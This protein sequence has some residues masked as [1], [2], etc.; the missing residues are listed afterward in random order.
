VNLYVAS[1][2]GVDWRALEPA[3]RINL[4]RLGPHEYRLQQR[5]E[6]KVPSAPGRYVVRAW[7][8]PD[9]RVAESDDDN[10]GSAVVSLVVGDVHAYPDLLVDLA[11]VNDLTARPGQTIPVPLVIENRG[12]KPAAGD[13]G[14]FETALFYADTIQADWGALDPVQTLTWPAVEPNG[15]VERIIPLAAPDH[16]GTYYVR[17]LADPTN[18]VIESNEDNFSRVRRIIVA[19]EPA[20]NRPPALGPLP[21]TIIAEGQA[22]QQ[23]LSAVDPDGDWL[24]FTAEPLPAGAVIRGDQFAWTPG[25]DQAGE[26]AV[27]VTVSDG[28][29]SD[30]ATW[31]IT[32]RD[33]NRPPVIQAPDRVEVY[34]NQALDF[35][36]VVTDP[37]GDAVD[38]TVENLPDGAALDV[39]G[40]VGRL[41]WA[42]DYDQ[43]GDHVVTFHADDGRAENHHAVVTVLLRVLDVNRP[44]VAAVGPDR[45][46]LDADGTG[47][48]IVH[49]EGSASFDPDGD[50]LVYTWLDGGGRVLY[51]GLDPNLVVDLDIGVYGLTLQVSDGRAV[52]RDSI[53]IR[54]L[55]NV[56]C[57]PIA[58]AGGD[59]IAIDD[60]GNGSAAV[61]LDG[62]GSHDPDGAITTYRW[63]R[64]GRTVG[65]AS[66]AD[67]DL[68]LG[69]HAI[70]LEVTDDVGA[71]GRD[72]IR[73]TVVANT[74]DPQAPILLPVPDMTIRENRR[75]E[76]ALI[77][78]DPD[79]DGV[80]FSAQPLPAGATLDPA[81]GRFTWRPGYARAGTYPI[82]FSARAGDGI[83]HQTVV[84]TVVDVPLAP[85]YGRW[86]QR[87]G[88][89]PAAPLLSPPVGSASVVPGRTLW[90][91]IGSAD[92]AVVYSVV[93][94]LPGLTIDAGTLHWTPTVDQLGSY[95]VSITA[96]L[97]DHVESAHVEIDVVVAQ[98]SAENP[99][100]DSGRPERRLRVLRHP[101][102]ETGANP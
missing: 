32:V 86:L 36:V 100:G 76:L 7:V 59:R 35:T 34:E 94:A 22:Y 92:P 96:Q 91:P 1:H 21:E 66:T 16:A 88:L 39:D 19:G 6:I 18:A 50:P 93:P 46:V 64:D 8:D 97:A 13:P 48:E 78:A 81:T 40:A 52:D 61:T 23:V 74:P 20:Q 42:P 17:V 89:Y 70:V 3:G 87:R 38:L 82:T 67:I 9:D 73:I 37:D 98:S 10:N 95:N 41:T 27:V 69:D 71:V 26:Y 54:V 77:A 62:S 63:I 28:R 79:G 99:A 57:P 85:W 30:V 65:T 58:D 29:N 84:I 101:I 53:R 44:P 68:P 31:S 83:T 5:M 49:V 55:P 56:N 51:S 15:V 43:A 80:T 14:T 2:E 102:E 4:D 12:L 60:D 47:G 45:D 90:L 25:Y 33:M 72:M 24:L 11:D 75:L